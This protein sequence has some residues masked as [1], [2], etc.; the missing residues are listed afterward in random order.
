MRVWAVFRRGRHAV[1]C[2]HA[3][4]DRHYSSRLDRRHRRRTADV[5]RGSHLRPSTAASAGPRG[6]PSA[7]LFPAGTDPTI[8]PFAV[9]DQVR[10]ASTASVRSASFR[11]RRR[12]P[13]FRGDF[14]SPAGPGPGRRP[15]RPRH[16]RRHKSRLL[17]VDG[18]LL[19]SH[20]GFTSTSA[21]SSGGAFEDATVPVTV[22][23]FSTA[24]TCEVG[25]NGG[26]LGS[27]QFPFGNSVFGDVWR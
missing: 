11:P 27:R 24:C 19:V 22:I 3:R 25:G 13:T 1:W 14:S 4:I 23:S 8:D 20:P 15:R 10:P 16:E 17:Q 21:G 7:F 5:H 18:V 6:S 2:H 26:G 9:A 12:V